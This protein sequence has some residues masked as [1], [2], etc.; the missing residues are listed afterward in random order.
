[1]KRHTSWGSDAGFETAQLMFV[2][3][4]MVLVGLVGVSVWGSKT[5]SAY[6][7]MFSSAG[8]V[9]RS[10]VSVVKGMSAGSPVRVEL[11]PKGDESKTVSCS[12]TLVGVTV[13]DS[14]SLSPNGA[15][16]FVLMSSSEKRK[17][18]A[19]RCGDG[20]PVSLVL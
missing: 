15:G 7:G 8:Y 3:V 5:G 1:M 11:S 16:G 13:V 4:A 6:K 9:L 12:L 17:M 10:D 2:V 14:Q 20:E 19:L 18:Y